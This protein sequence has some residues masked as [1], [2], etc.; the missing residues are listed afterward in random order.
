MLLA[1]VFMFTGIFTVPSHGA[2]S[3][4][5]EGDFQ[6]HERFAG[7][8]LYY[9]IDVSRWQ[10]DIDW[11]KVKASGVDF[12]IIQAGH[13]K[14]SL[15]D[16]GR[17]EKDIKFDRNIQ[18]AKANGIHTGVY[19]FSQALTKNEAVEEAEFLLNI[20]KGTS[21]DLPVF[22]DM[23]TGSGYRNKPVFGI[24]PSKRDDLAEICNAFCSRICQAGYRAGVYANTHTLTNNINVSM[25]T[26]KGY[27]IW[28]AQYGTRSEY[29]GNYTIWQYS[30]K[31]SVPGIEGNVDLDF[32]YGNAFFSG[33][34]KIVS[35]AGKVTGLKKSSAT[36]SA[37]VIRWKGQ[38]NV[39]GYK[40]YRSTRHGGTYKRIGTTGKTSFKD[41]GLSP[42]KEYYYKVRAY[43]SQGTAE[44]SVYYGALTRP[45]YDRYGQ[46]KASKVLRTH[47]GSKYAS[48]RKL[49]KG[50]KVTIYGYALDGR[51]NKW[52]KVKYKTSKKTYKG[53]IL[54]GKVTIT[55]KVT[56]AGKAALRKDAGKSFQSYGTI[57]KGKRLT[58]LGTKTVKGT[59]WYKVKYKIGKKKRT[60]YVI[61]SAVKA[62]NVKY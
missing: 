28:N 57:P 17:M 14:R 53:Y 35:A 22:I 41:T 62:V 5:L 61:G 9:G 33:S 46:L 29:D 42:G 30:S 59:T 47:P 55:K 8:P 37:I 11:K 43:D 15:E 25:I 23:E 52:Y 36:S 48:V 4:F 1:L 58:I 10:G 20:L 6:H 45:L 40:V 3:P 2:S 39:K 44:S 19:F 27:T 21:L 60:G 50:N 34:S 13:R 24:T 51:G 7:K 12:A 56:T 38:K 49:K 32:L 16:N 26:E 54:S 31:G 18:G